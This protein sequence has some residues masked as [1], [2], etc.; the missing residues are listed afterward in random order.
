[1]VSWKE[2]YGTHC[3]L[4]KK[5]LDAL[6]KALFEL[7]GTEKGRQEA[8]LG[9]SRLVPA[10]VSLADY[11]HA[12]EVREYC[13]RCLIRISSFPYNEIFPYKKKVLGAA[14]KGTDDKKRRV[15]KVAVAC[16]EAWM[17]DLTP[18]KP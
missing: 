10:L 1:M 11:Q 16:R 3:H 13:F 14:T 9:L 5:T 12:M 2:M 6:L 18:N 17:Q 7:L 15:R 4:L 8:G